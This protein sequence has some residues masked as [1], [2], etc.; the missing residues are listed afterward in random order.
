MDNSFLIAGR[1]IAAFALCASIPAIAADPIAAIQRDNGQ[2]YK[3]RALAACISAAYKGSR[4][5][6]D[7]SITQRA[8]LE[9]TYYD[10][11]NGNAATDQ[12]VEKYLHRDYGNPVEGYADAKFDLLKCIDM[13][14]SKELDEQVRKYVPHPDWIGDKPN[15]KKRK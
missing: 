11:D 10:D 4:A 14:H 15:T 12:L 5:G 9:W 2:N 3:D 6:E 13:Y 8:F 1:L 7:A